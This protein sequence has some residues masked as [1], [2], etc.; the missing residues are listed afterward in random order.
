LTPGLTTI[1]IL[2]AVGS[3]TDFFG[4][5]ICLNS[6]DKLTLA[7]GLTFLVGQHSY[8]LVLEMAGAT[9]STLPHACG[10]G[11]GRRVRSRI[12]PLFR[13]APYSAQDTSVNRELV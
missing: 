10:E 8:S 7:V 3:W 1:A 4:P 5:L 11:S 13:G 9:V 12:V 2:T 6:L